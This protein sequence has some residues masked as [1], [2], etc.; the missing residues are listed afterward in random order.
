MNIILHIGNY[1][2]G[3][4]A[5]QNYLYLN[6]ALLA[7]QGIC[8]EGADEPPLCCHASFTYSLL[9]A[10]LQQLDLFGPYAAHPLWGHIRETPEMLWAQI[11]DAAERAHCHTV[12]LSHESIFCETMRTFA[13]L[14]GTLDRETELQIL[15]TLHSLLHRLVTPKSNR[16]DIYLYLRR[17]DDYLESQYNQYIKA[18]W[19]EEPLPPLPDFESFVRLQPVTLDYQK[20]LELL[21][22]LYGREHLHVRAYTPGDD[23]YRS[24]CSTA[25]GNGGGECSTKWRKPDTSMENRSL[26][27]DALFFKQ[28]FLSGEAARNPVIGEIL[29]AYSSDHPDACRYTLFTPELHAEIARAYNEKN[30]QINQD[31]IHNSSDHLPEITYSKDRIPYPGL[32]PEHLMKIMD[33]L[34]TSRKDY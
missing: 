2:T 4:T 11:C 18:P 3:S 17:Q 23:I 30:R 9:R 25:L 27:L 6:R 8:Y 7:E 16:V 19:Y 28:R 5:L 20:P 33:Y 21:A 15:H 12:L 10:A 1:K 22:G 13:G 34:G 31:Y 29:S 32:A 14:H 24:F 26:S